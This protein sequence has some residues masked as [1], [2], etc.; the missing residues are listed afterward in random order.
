MLVEEVLGGLKV[1]GCGFVLAAVEEHFEVVGGE[2]VNQV[3]DCL[4]SDLLLQLGH[5]LFGPLV[6]LAVLLV[7]VLILDDNPAYFLDD[8]GVLLGFLFFFSWNIERF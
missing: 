7:S 6:V 8:I 5:H 4:L 2:A 1:L 3:L